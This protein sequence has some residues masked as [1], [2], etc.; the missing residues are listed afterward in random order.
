M[1]SSHRN[2]SGKDVLDMSSWTVFFIFICPYKPIQSYC[3]ILRQ[4]ADLEFCPKTYPLPLKISLPTSLKR[5]TKRCDGH[6]LRCAFPFLLGPCQAAAHVFHWL[7][8]AS[9]H[10]LSAVSSKRNRQPV[11]PDQHKRCPGQVAGTATSEDRRTD[12]Q[13]DKQQHHQT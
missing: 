6:Y 3:A 2:G 8:E 5:P 9:I 11:N 12:N 4:S 1:Q 10:L 7:L 13:T